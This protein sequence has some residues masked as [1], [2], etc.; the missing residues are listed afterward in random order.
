MNHD[1]GHDKSLNLWDI[2]GRSPQKNVLPP[3][4]GARD[5]SRVLRSPQG[6]LSWELT[7]IKNIFVHG[8][9]WD[10][11]WDFSKIIYKQFD[12]ENMGASE[13]GVYRYTLQIENFTGRKNV[14]NTGLRAPFQTNPAHFMTHFKW[15]RWYQENP[16]P[17]GW[18]L[19]WSQNT[20]VKIPTWKV[21]PWV[22]IPKSWKLH[23]GCHFC[24]LNLAFCIQ[25]SCENPSL[26]LKGFFPD[27]FRLWIIVDLTDGDSP[28]DSQESVSSPQVYPLVN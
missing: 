2:L 23:G 1:K 4:H 11:S 25:P 7:Y 5:R 19:T 27:S 8:I 6:D 10:I 17:N 26:D 21:G 22:S 28:Q 14:T 24:S 13:N 15:V 9:Q 3:W 12:V 16:H 20:G 18:C